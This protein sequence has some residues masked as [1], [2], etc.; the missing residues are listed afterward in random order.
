[1]DINSKWGW[2]I[3]KRGPNLIAHSSNGGDLGIFAIKKL[4]VKHRALTRLRS[5]VRIQTRL[6][7]QRLSKRFVDVNILTALQ[8]GLIV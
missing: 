5:R 6:N 8:T 3:L 1:M 2:Q 7:R 4:K